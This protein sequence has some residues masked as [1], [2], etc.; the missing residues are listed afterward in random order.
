M[1]DLSWLEQYEQQRAG[2][3]RQATTAIAAILPRLHELGVTSVII[4]FDGYGDSGAVEQPTAYAGETEFQLPEDLTAALIA[5]AECLLP[6]GWENNGGAFGELELNV[7]ERKLTRDH[8]WRV[9]DVE[10]ES[11][12]Y[13]L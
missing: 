3:R 8:N 10:C 11:E 6:E 13:P 7:G 9:E 5:A 1:S 12:E 4:P 2:E